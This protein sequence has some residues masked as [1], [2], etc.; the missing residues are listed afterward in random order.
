MG[1]SSAHLAAIL[2]FSFWGLFPIYWKLFPEIGS[3]DL[4][5]HR[6]LWS[7]VTLIFIL[8]LKKDLNKLA[9]IFKDPKKAMWLTLS[10]A[11]IAGNW[12]LYIY[13]VHIGKILEASL[14]YFL[15]PLLNVFMGWL[16]L[17]EK[18]R[19]GQWPAILLGLIAITWLGILNGITHF[20]WIALSLSLSFALYALIRKLVSVS[21]LVGLSFETT[22]M[23]IP[24]LVIW[25]FQPTNPDS[26]LEYLPNW[27]IAVL[28][29]SGIITCL[30]LILF[31]FAAKNLPL[32]TLGFINYLSPILKFVC[33]WIIFDEI[34]SPEKLQAF[35]LI[36][37]ALIWYT[38][39][40]IINKKKRK[41]V[42]PV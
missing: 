42:I 28:G 26:I 16:I 25:H 33:G 36:W 30:P 37:I 40:S 7:F 4:F 5:A 6:L 31:G 27:K 23:I 34:L 15:N 29:L 39:E 11:L 41:P 9:A 38:A 21:S 10:G 13:A 2:S 35:S 22:M 12:L 8:F 17:K 1:L 24:T 14:G 3:W 20:P 32:G 18:I 19:V